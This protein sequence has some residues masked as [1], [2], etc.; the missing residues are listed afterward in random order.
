MNTE[1][2]QEHRTESD[3]KKIIVAPIQVK[4]R[5]LCESPVYMYNVLCLP[6]LRPLIQYLN[7]HFPKFGD[8]PT[9]T[10]SI[11]I[12]EFTSATK[13]LP[14]IVIVQVPVGVLAFPPIL[15]PPLHLHLQLTLN[16]ERQSGVLLEHAPSTQTNGSGKK[17]MQGNSLTN[18]FRVQV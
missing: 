14:F 3:R 10:S 1:N 4:H 8:R 7:S 9:G 2:L 5:L 17:R 16:T 6:S 15:T 12:K 11:T 13:E 18:P